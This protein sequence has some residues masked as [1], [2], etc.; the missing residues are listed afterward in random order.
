M[1]GRDLTVDG[2]PPACRQHPGGRR[3]PSGA[4]RAPGNP[5]ELGDACTSPPL[6]DA[7][8]FMGMNA[9]DDETRVACMSFM[10]QRFDEGVE[11]SWEQVGRCDDIVWA[12]ERDVQDAYYPFMDVLHSTMSVTRR[13]YAAAD[14]ELALRGDGLAGLPLHEALAVAMAANADA[15]L[16]TISPRLHDRPDLPVRRPTASAVAEFPDPIAE[17]YRRSLRLRVD[18]GVL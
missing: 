8:V 4:D 16:V 10:A 2:V 3:R 11:M 9:R 18:E 12:Y 17:L 13:A 1:P 5:A 15:R 14:L 6:I 7:S